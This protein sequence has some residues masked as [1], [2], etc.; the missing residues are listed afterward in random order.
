M[1]AL[2][3]PSSP[4]LNQV[5]TA[6]GYSWKWN[7]A[8]WI[9]LPTIN[10]GTINGTTIG[11]TT[12]ASGAFTTLNASGQLTVTGAAQ[13]AFGSAFTPTAWGVSSID[14]NHASGGLLGLYY[15]GSPKGYF[16]ALSGGGIGVNTQGTGTLD[17]NVN[18]TQRA[19]ISGTGLSVTGALSSSGQL[20]VGDSTTPAGLTVLNSLMSSD[21][22]A[23]ANLAIRKSATAV[24]GPNLSFLKSRGTAASPSVVAN[25]DFIGGINFNGYDGANY[26]LGAQ[27]TAV[28]SGTPGTSDLPT[29]LLF[30][31]SPDG[32]AQPQERMRISST[33]SVTFN[34]ASGSPFTTFNYGSTGAAEYRLRSGGTGGGDIISLAWYNST[35]TCKMNIFTDSSAGH[36]R[37]LSSGNLSL[38]TNQVGITGSN[39]RV[40]IDTAGNVKFNAY[41]AG[42]LV[43]DAS[44]NITASSDGR[45]KDVLGTFDRGLAAICGIT[46][47]LFKWNAESGLD[48]EAVN[49]GFIAQD[50]LPH[51]PEAIHEK[52]DRYSM[53]DRP[54]IAALVNAVKELKALNDALVTRVTK[55]E[56]KA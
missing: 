44:G 55:L 2:N 43:T 5:Y 30:Y 15:G 1:A 12:P 42:T 33:G 20:T 18:G 4:T 16:I 3:F 39:E 6:N 34:V 22:A 37:I 38:H 13:N 41:G 35:P 9:S 36:T 52:N 40:Y 56:N 14:I 47:Q 25:G 49:A 21:T 23:G 28:V 26:G 31:T 54:L 46:P 10:G 11:S 45:M 17:F 48:T 29:D 32:T 8:S 27:I 24:N 7:G 51:I 53:S 19:Q 50:V